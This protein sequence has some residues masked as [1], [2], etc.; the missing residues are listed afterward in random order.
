MRYRSVYGLKEELEDMTAEALYDIAHHPGAEIT[1]PALLF[2]AGEITDR[3]LIETELERFCAIHEISKDAD[4]L[5]L[6]CRGGIDHPCDE[7]DDIIPSGAGWIAAEWG[8]RHY[9]LDVR[10]PYDLGEAYMHIIKSRPKRWA[11][12]FSE[13]D[14]LIE[15]IREA[16]NDDRSLSIYGG[17][18][19]VADQGRY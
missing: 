17:A 8:I 13:D 18:H 15:E 14:D 2:I 6:L 11:L 16:W 9:G 7:Y 19:G 1:S 5:Q 10:I 12:V 3:H 4:R